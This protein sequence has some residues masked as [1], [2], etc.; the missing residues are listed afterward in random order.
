MDLAHGFGTPGLGDVLILD[1]R[2]QTGWFYLL[3]FEFM[4]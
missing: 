1:P 4:V 3:R 2:A